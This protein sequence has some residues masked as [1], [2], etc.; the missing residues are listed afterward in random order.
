MI[1]DRLLAKD[2]ILSL[3]RFVVGSSRAMSYSRAMSFEYFQMREGRVT[4]TT[5]DTKTFC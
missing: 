4:Y 2:L 1:S 5:V 3:S